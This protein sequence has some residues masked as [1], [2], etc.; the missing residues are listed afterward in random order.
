LIKDSSKPIISIKNLSISFLKK[1]EVVKVVNNISF[2]LLKDEVLG[3]VGESG[4]GKSVTALSILKLLPKNKTISKGEVIY[5]N[6]NLLELSE[7]SIRQVRQK[8]ISII[9]QEPMSVLNPTMKCVDQLRECFDIEKIDKKDIENEISLL[10]KKVKLGKVDNFNSKYPHQLSGG[11]KQ[12]LMI[13]M[14]IACKPKLLIADEPTT[15]LDVTV[16]KEIIELLLKIKRTEGLSIIFISHDLALV[17]EIADRLIVMFKGKIIEKGKA[18][19]IFSNPIENYTKGLLYSRP[20]NKVKLSKLPTVSDYINN[21]VNNTIVNDKEIEISRQKIYSNNPILEIKNLDKYY[22]QNKVWF[23]KK[24]VFKALDGI[25]LK[26]FKGETLGLVGESG[27]GKSTLVKTIVQIEKA[28]NGS[29]FYKGV[30]ITKLS[31]SEL[32]HYRKDVQLIFQ[33]PDSS[34]NPKKTIGSLIM[35]PMI[36]HKIVKKDK[37]H[38]TLCINLLKDVGLK[39]SDFYKYPHELSGGQKQRVG[40]ARAI[41][42]EPKVL[43]CD[44][45]VSALDVSVQAQVLNLLSH[46]KKKLKLTY[47]FISHDLSVVKYMADKIVVM[48]EGVFKE[49]GFSED[50]YNNPK[51]EYTKKLIEAIPKGVS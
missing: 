23:K 28:S 49:I 16:Q 48:K 6:T 2:N 43:I 11:Q 13:A 14:A 36:V 24:E 35:E 51:M 17:S 21:S 46:L 18:I 47:I 34:L 29:I 41:S 37:S 33:D 20:N 12:R 42:V 22:I 40:I 31:K 44:E 45:S 1:N 3:I 32:N 50:I 26:L 7:V 38:K 25:N 10:I 27:C 5:N 8:D 9:F 30:D 15:A 39:K 4:S 19:E